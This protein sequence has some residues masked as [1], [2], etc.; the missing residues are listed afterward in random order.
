MGDCYKHAWHGGQTGPECPEC[1]EIEQLRARVEE[2]ESEGIPIEIDECGQP[3]NLHVF[4]NEM[5]DAAVKMAG[6][7]N[8]AWQILMEFNIFKCEGCGGSGKREPSFTHITGMACPDCDGHGWVI[9]RE[10]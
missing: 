8:D 2:L 3:T 1:A 6:A 4:T 9:Q 5:I 7:E 10:S